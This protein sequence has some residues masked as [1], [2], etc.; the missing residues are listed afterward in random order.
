MPHGP[1]DNDPFDLIGCARDRAAEPAGRDDEPDVDI[2]DR[3]GCGPLTED[4]IEYF[5]GLDDARELEREARRP[6]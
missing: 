2:D 3:T 1:F 4:E 6:P 5:R